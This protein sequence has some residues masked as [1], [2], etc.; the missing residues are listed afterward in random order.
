[1]RQVIRRK[2]LPGLYVSAIA[3]T[4]KDLQDASAGPFAVTKAGLFTEL[5]KGVRDLLRGV[6][7]K[8]H[9]KSKFGGRCLFFADTQLAAFGIFAISEQ[10][11]G[12]RKPM[13]Q[14]HTE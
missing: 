4:S 11:R 12:E 14:P 7:V 6:T 2:G 3:F 10:M 5:D 9:I 1:M 13:V 8:I